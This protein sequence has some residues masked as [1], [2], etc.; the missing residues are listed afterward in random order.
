MPPLL[1]KRW[2]CRSGGKGMSKRCRSV[3]VTARSGGLPGFCFAQRMSKRDRR[4][5]EVDV[6]ETLKRTNFDTR[7]RGYGR[8]SDRRKAHN[9]GAT[10]AFIGRAIA[11]GRRRVAEIERRCPGAK[12]ALSCGHSRAECWAWPKMWSSGRGRETARG[13]RTCWTGLANRTGQNGVTPAAR[14]RSGLESAGLE[15]AVRLLVSTHCEV[16]RG[17]IRRRARAV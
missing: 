9:R 12:R 5:C 13:D 2:V 11:R 15:G 14:R 10:R 4:G 7:A 8:G 3:E 17:W 16:S 6:E 1:K